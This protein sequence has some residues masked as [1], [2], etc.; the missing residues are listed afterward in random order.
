MSKPDIWKS[1]RP[2]HAFFFA[3]AVIG[4]VKD[5]TLWGG[6]VF[7]CSLCV[8]AIFSLIVRNKKNKHNGKQL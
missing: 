5:G 6:A 1:Q 3:L 4:Y 2:F 8:T 7:A